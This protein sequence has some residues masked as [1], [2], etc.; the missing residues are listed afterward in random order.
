MIHEEKMA[1]AVVFSRRAN[2]ETREVEA[3][4]ILRVFGAIPEDF[5]LA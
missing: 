5:D 4:V 2:A 1:G 3:A